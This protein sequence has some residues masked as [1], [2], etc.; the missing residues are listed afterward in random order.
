M[1]LY[2]GG[3]DGGTYSW[4][5]GTAILKDSRKKLTRKWES[6]R[7]ERD[8]MEKSCKL[9]QIVWKYAVALNKQ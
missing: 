4:N 7:E 6:S 5:K 8:R 9:E 1:K 3:K 2:Y